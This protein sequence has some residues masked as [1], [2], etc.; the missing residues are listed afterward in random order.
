[1]ARR[2]TFNQG[3]RVVPRIV[4][5]ALDGNGSGIREVHCRIGIAL[6]IDTR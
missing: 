6:P 3:W 4:V 2:F 5:T 1:M